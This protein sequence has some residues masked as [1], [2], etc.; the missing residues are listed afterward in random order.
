MKY[1]ILA[2]G[3]GG[4]SGLS[5]VHEYLFSALAKKHALAGVIN[6][7]LSGFWKYWNVLYC[8]WRLPSVSKYLHPVRTIL[9]EE[10]SYYRMRTKYY[11]LK[12]AEACEWKI[13]KL[14][15]KYDVALQT[16]WQPAIR[17]KPVKPHFIYVDFTMKM[18]ERLYPSYTRFYTEAG[19]RMWLKLQTETHRNATRIFTF[20]SQ[21]KNS[22]IT[23]CGVEP[24][25][26]CNV[27][28]GVNLEKIPEYEKV[29]NGKSMLFICTPSTFR[30]KG[31][32]ILL[33]AFKELQK[34]IPD[35]KLHIVGTKLNLRNKSITTEGLIKHSQLLNYYENFSV[36]VMPTIMGGYQ[37]L[38]EGMAYKCPCIGGATTCSDII[39]E[40]IAGFLVPPND[41]KELADKLILL[42]EDENLMKKMGDQ[43]Q[44]RVKKYFTWDLVVDR[45]TKQFDQIMEK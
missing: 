20:S 43:G 30:L 16:S 31:G 11:V 4:L 5:G 35:A 39:E 21:T 7:R 40:G 13:Q 15:D 36:V 26:V 9:G 6:T 28:V 24:E 3:A 42:L 10:V 19:K 27:L 34:E 38:L 29:Y 33:R 2:L 23:D 12:R 18:T 44:A 17:K 25:K 14:H 45:M 1:R 22:I 8:F 32:N 37:T 41:Y